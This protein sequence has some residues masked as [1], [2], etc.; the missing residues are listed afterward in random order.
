MVLFCLVILMWKLF[1]SDR[2]GIFGWETV[3]ESTTG[4]G[5]S[6]AVLAFSAQTQLFVFFVIQSLYLFLVHCCFHHLGRDGGLL[7]AGLRCTGADSCPHLH[8]LQ[9]RSQNAT[10]SF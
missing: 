8:N 5:H 4:S 1:S 10:C 3:A 2:K 9:R 6:G 7:V